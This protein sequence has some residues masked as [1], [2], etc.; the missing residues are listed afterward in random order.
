MIFSAKQASRSFILHHRGIAR[1]LVEKEIVGVVVVQRGDFADERIAVDRVERVIQKWRQSHRLAWTQRNCSAR[2][3]TVSHSVAGNEDWRL[4]KTA[5]F[6]RI[7]KSNDQ[8]ARL[9]YRLD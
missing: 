1:Q 7:V 3:N 2:I 9:L 4:R 5:I 8:R 6:G